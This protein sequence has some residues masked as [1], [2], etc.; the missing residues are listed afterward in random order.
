VLNSE[1][2]TRRHRRGLDLTVGL[3]SWASQFMG[4]CGLYHSPEAKSAPSRKSRKS[5][6]KC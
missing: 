2:E 3:Q 4:W 6:S 1:A 5:K